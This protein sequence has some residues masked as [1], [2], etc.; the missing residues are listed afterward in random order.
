MTLEPHWISQKSPC[1]SSMKKALP[2][3]AKNHAFVDGNKRAAFLS[4][5]LFLAINGYLL[6]ADQI[7]AIQT[8]FRVASGELNEEDL[9]AWVARNAMRSRP[10]THR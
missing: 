8:M 1:S 4:I 7:D 2:S 6:Q 10:S 3:V 9:T 5:G